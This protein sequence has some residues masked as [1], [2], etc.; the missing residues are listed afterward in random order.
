M[1]EATAALSEG[2]TLKDSAMQLTAT[3]TL[4][5]SSAVRVPSVVEV[6]RNSQMARASFCL[7]VG[8]LYKHA[9]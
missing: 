9:G 3:S 2:S 5:L 7:E 1:A 6:V 8:V 4:S